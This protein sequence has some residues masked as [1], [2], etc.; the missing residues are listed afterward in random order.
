MTDKE[1]KDM[2]RS[3]R[4]FKE[5]DAKAIECL[6][7]GKDIPQDW[8]DFGKMLRDAT[9]NVDDYV[10]VTTDDNGVT[11]INCNVPLYKD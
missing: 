11:C 1:K 4:D 5:F 2:I 6:S 3:H 7:Q 10:T 9:D 8:L